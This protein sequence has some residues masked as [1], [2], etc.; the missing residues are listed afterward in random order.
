MG[1]FPYGGH[2]KDVYL[3]LDM[4][5]PFVENLMRWNHHQALSPSER[6]RRL[7]RIRRLDGLETNPWNYHYFWLNFKPSLGL[8]LETLIG[9]IPVLDLESIL[10][11]VLM[12]FIPML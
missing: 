2:H 5:M 11:R 8:L 10:Y 7:S 4:I 6:I 9:W 1:H 12:N 3:Y